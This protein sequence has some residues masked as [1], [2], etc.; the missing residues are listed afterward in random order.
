[1]KK[2]SHIALFSAVILS[3]TA[4]SHATLVSATSATTNMG[5]GFGTSLTNSINGTGLSSLSLNATHSATL[6]AN[7]WVS[8]GILNGDITFSL[9]GLTTIDGFSFWNQNNGGPGTLGSTGI[10]NLAISYSADNDTFVPLPGAP[11][12]FAQ[13]TL[14]LSQAQ[15]FSFA[16]VAA[17]AVRFSVQS[18]YGDPNESG[19]AEIQFNRAVPEPGTALFGLALAGFCGAVR[20]ARAKV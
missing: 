1:M 20:R 13:S 17:R 10:R 9:A 15:Q 3:L 12:T 2:H 14:D 5:S 11:T 16:P 19:F 7:S 6:P 4:A 8:L 18:N